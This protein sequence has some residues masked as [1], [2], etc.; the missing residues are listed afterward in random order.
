MSSH[1]DE[2]AGGDMDVRDEARAEQR[3]FAPFDDDLE[4]AKIT[5]RTGSALAAEPDIISGKILTVQG[6]R[7]AVLDLRLGSKV[8][9]N[10]GAAPQ[11]CSISPDDAQLL[12]GRYV[13]LANAIR[14]VQLPGRL[15]FQLD[16]QDGRRPGTLAF[17]LKFEEQ[18]TQPK[19][20]VILATVDLVART[21]MI[22]R[23]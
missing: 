5:C 14:V 19:R 4:E 2:Y 17:R 7:T 12:P 8:T 21:V 10:P 22:A 11:F 15:L 16:F 6:T 9:F 3:D 1:H 13:N 18:R 20:A 23:G